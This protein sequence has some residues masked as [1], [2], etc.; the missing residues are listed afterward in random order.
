MT[1]RGSVQKIRSTKWVFDCEVTYIIYFPALF[2][3]F[4]WT[5][6]SIIC[7][8]S[9]AKT[10]PIISEPEIHSSQSLDNISGFLVLMSE[11]LIAA[12]ESAHG[13]EQVN[14]VS[15]LCCAHTY[16]V[17][18]WCHLQLFFPIYPPLPAVCSLLK[19]I[20]AMVAAELAQQASIEAAAQSV[21][22]RVRRLH[23]D[24]YVSGRQRA[25]YCSRHEDMTL[26]I[27]TISY[28]LADGALTPTQGTKQMNIGLVHSKQPASTKHSYQGIIGRHAADTL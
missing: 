28:P 16:M 27:R 7:A 5:H 21:V 22:D 2:L 4:C 9:L 6:L 24:V 13:P 11:G 14:Q 8:I 18:I 1:E 23:H 15:R 3:L 19:E 17:C 25:V 10:K 26:L 20:V 12:L